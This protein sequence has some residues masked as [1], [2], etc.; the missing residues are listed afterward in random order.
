MRR[1]R[2][3]EKVAALMLALMAAVVL[4]AGCV[5]NFGWEATGYLMAVIILIMA[6]AVLGRE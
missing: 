2:M 3:Q 6:L 4:L 5:D 1:D